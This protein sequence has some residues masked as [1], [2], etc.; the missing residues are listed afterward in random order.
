MRRPCPT[1]WRHPVVGLPRELLALLPFTPGGLGF[2]EAGL[3]G[4][5]TVAG[6]PGSDA[7]AATLLYRL[8]A[9]WLPI[10]AGGVAYLLFRHRYH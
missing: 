1:R 10:P 9:Y 4:M 2:V 7:L 3:V 6:V 5:L 8:A